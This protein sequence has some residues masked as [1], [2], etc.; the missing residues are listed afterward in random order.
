MA[1]QVAGKLDLLSRRDTFVDRD[2]FVFPSDAGDTIDGS[3]LR[4]RFEVAR[5]KAGLRKIRFHDL[6]HSFG[7]VA[8]NAALT[9]HE[10]QAWM[11][12]ADYRTTARYLHYRTRGDEARRLAA[13]FSPEPILQ[14]A[15]N[16]EGSTEVPEP[17]AACGNLP[18]LPGQYPP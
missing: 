10:L 15:C 16:Q 17:A 8:A 1:P 9:G 12:H 18:G 2:D 5:T 14:P 7:T 11:G 4:R 3:A 13:A 6:R